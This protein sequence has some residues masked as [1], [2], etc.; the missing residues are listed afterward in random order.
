LTVG[1]KMRMYLG[2][3]HEKVWEVT[4][5]EYIVLDPASP[6]PR[7]QE[8]NQYNTMALNTI[9]NGIDSKVFEQIKDLD[10]AS[11]V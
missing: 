2:S 9:Y 4:E 5:K 8:N 3:I 11:E 6:T 10:R 1:R 7:D